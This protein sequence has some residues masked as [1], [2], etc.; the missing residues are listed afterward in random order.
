MIDTFSQ[1]QEV[2]IAKTKPRTRTQSTHTS[3]INKRGRLASSSYPNYYPS[4]TNVSWS[5]LGDGNGANSLFR[6]TEGG[7]LGEKVEVISESFSQ[8]EQHRDP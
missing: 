6:T 8:D 3:K 7:R 4:P 2:H 5:S 1:N